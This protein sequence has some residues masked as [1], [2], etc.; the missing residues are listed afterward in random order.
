M[1]NDIRFGLRSIH[2]DSFSCA[3]ESTLHEDIPVES[4]QYRYGT[5]TTIN[6]SENVIIIQAEINYFTSAINLI[7][8]KVSLLFQVDSLNSIISY[9]SETREISFTPDILPT[10]LSIT[11]GTIRGILHEKV[12]G[13]SLEGYPLPLISMPALTKNNNIIVSQE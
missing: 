8:L 11:C 13:N 4:L 1:S 5:T 7:E 2:E 9:N 6:I 10:F 12:K 3:D